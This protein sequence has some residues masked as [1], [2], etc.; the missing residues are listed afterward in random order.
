MSEKIR[1]SDTNSQNNFKKK[2][3]SFLERMKEDRTFAMYVVCGIAVA[4]VIIV[5]AIVFLVSNGK[6]KQEDSQS[7]SA[8]TVSGN[9]ETVSAGYVVKDE[10]LAENAFENV[11]ALI[12]TYFVALA[13]GDKATISSLKLNSDEKELIK[14]EK[15]SAYIEN[16]QNIKVYTKSGPIENSYVA[17]V[18]YEIKFANLN[19][20]APG[21]TTL[22]IC[23]NPDGQLYIYDG[24]L[25]QNVT[26]YIKA[27]AASADVV[28]LF[29][30]VEVKYNEAVAADADLKTFMDGLAD[31]L[32]AEV[33]E[34]LAALEAATVSADVVT[35]TPAETP[36]EETPAETLIYWVTTLDTVNVRSSDSENADKLG[37]VDKGT[38]LMIYEVRENGWSRVDFNGQPGFIKTEFLQSAGTTVADPNAATVETAPAETTETETAPAETTGSVTIKETVN[39]RASASESGDKVGVAYQGENYDLIM[40]QADGWCKISYKGQT[41]Y[42]KTEFVE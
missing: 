22:Y 37:K 36:V 42:V 9:V 7:V 15:K 35:E 27:V 14:I 20:L 38:T 16:F 2:V 26:N 3:V 40:K 21:L 39:V 5:L 12:N 17:F 19:T 23:T 30:E 18:Y 8:N 1:Q 33:S 10:N 28:A 13:E 25:D 34:A 6:N 11:N 24:E 32:E 29:S 41:A 31:K 4:V